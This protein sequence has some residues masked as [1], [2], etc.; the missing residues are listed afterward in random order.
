MNDPTS[1]QVMSVI[2]TCSGGAGGSALIIDHLSGTDNC[3]CAYR[4]HVGNV[5]ASLK[6]FLNLNDVVKPFIK[7]LKLFIREHATIQNSPCAFIIFLQVRDVEFTHDR[8]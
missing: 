4:R 8:D 3:R 6:L 2:A 5:S 1:S 7:Y